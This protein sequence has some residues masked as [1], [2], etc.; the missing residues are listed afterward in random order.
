M[1]FMRSWVR[2]PSSPP[3]FYAFLL[4]EGGTAGI[5]LSSLEMRGFFFLS[6][7]CAHELFM[8]SWATVTS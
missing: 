6:V 8:C 7:D 1:A 2:I 4:T 5:G 3:F